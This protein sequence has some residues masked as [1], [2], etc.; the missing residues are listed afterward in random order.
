MQKK[1]EETK[2]AEEMQKVNVK[3]QQARYDTT[4]QNKIRIYTVY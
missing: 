4:V 2:V 1:K 3:V